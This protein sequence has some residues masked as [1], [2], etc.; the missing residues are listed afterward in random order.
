MRL[1]KALVG[2]LVGG[3]GLFGYVSHY[4]FVAGTGVSIGRVENANGREDITISSTVT[5][6][7]SSVTGTAPISCSPTTGAVSCSLT[8][9]L[10]VPQGGTAD[11]TLT[12]HAVLLG[13]GTSPVAFAS[14]GSTTNLPLIS[15]GAGFDPL[16]SVL[17]TAGGGT[18][19]SS[20]TG[21]NILQCSGGVWT[22][23]APPSFVKSGFTDGSVIGT[24]LLTVGG[25]FQQVADTLTMTSVPASGVANLAYS[26]EA[27][28]P[29]APGGCEATFQA[30]V[31]GS[32]VLAEDQTYTALSHGASFRSSGRWITLWRATG[33]SAGSHTFDLF[34]TSPSGSTGACNVQHGQIRADIVTQ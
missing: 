30:R 28:I 20:C 34:G 2:G 31:D 4:N 3:L 1:G 23:A 6:G 13:E 32:S 16:F 22:Q 27:V 14:P 29:S 5:G 12:A 17:Q 24:V 33:L 8:T 18:G 25:A 9:P 7:V 21:S 19:L 10:T 15:N 26:I 11:S